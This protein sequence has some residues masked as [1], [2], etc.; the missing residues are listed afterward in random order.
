MLFFS[1]ESQFVSMLAISGGSSN[2]NIHHVLAYWNS[3][4]QMSGL[5]V[6][7][8]ADLTE[9][10]WCFFQAAPNPYSTP[11]HP[12]KKTFSRYCSNLAWMAK[13]CFSTYSSLHMRARSSTA[14]IIFPQRSIK[15]RERY[16]S[17]AP[18]PF[19]CFFTQSLSCWWFEWGGC[20]IGA[21]FDTCWHCLNKFSFSFTDYMNV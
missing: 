10:L 19:F 7:P 5:T 14:I 8:P 17:S 4:S 18:I 16:S 6:R 9:F 1:Q 2:W 15:C 20:R 11:T 3:P 12:T 13:H 21:A